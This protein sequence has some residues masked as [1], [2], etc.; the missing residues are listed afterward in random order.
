MGDGSSTDVED[1]TAELI[2]FYRLNGLDRAEHGREGLQWSFEG[3]DQPFCVMRR[4][5][6]IVGLSA[7]IRSRFKLGGEV[8]SAFQAVDSFVSSSMRGKGVFTRLARAYSAHAE[9]AGVD[10]IW[11]FP[12]NNAAPA[13]FGK[14]GWTNFG[15]VPFLVRPLRAGYFLRRLRLPGD[16]RLSFARD[17]GL[18]PMT[19]AEPWIDDLWASYSATIRCAVLRDSATIQH[20]LFDGPHAASYR[21]VGDSQADGSGGALVATREA[22]KHGGSIA[23]LMEAMGGTGLEDVLQSE[24]ARL[25][26][27]G[28]ELVLA[29]SFPW[30]PNYRTLRRCGFVPFPTALR[31]IEIWFGA[32]SYSR[33][34][35]AADDP[36]NW[37]LSYLDSD[38][39]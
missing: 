26:D 5:D 3:T 15:Q 36:R 1:L 33:R 4:G 7:Y 39:I 32:K 27:R 37:Y 2:D 19:V 16:F 18:A 17:R 29:W 23:Y 14:L 25:R 8:G 12:N 38:T 24:L 6:E 10:L 21:V 20:R 11:G 30:S 31:P 9:E 34:G 28:M 22:A 35:A 13:W